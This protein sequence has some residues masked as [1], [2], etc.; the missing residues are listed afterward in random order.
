MF[1]HQTLDGWAFDVELLVM[2]NKAGF[3]VGEVPIDW[4]Y[5]EGS[6]MTLTKGV[7]AVIDVARVGARNLLGKYRIV[8]RKSEL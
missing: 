3:T 1:P 5:R 7:L 2:A 6:K 8:G 4:Y